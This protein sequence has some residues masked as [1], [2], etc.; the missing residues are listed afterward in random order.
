MITEQPGPAS[1]NPS[2]SLIVALDDPELKR[3]RRRNICFMV[4]AGLSCLACGNVFFGVLGLVFTTIA[5]FDF[6]AGKKDSGSKNSRIGLVLTIIGIL[7]V[8]VLVLVVVLLAMS[9]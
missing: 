2:N 4:L 6:G 1:D 3:L 8:A 5:E 9:D 7:V